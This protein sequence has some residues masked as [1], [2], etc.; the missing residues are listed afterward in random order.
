MSSNYC[1]GKSKSGAPCRAPAGRD[2]LC[3]FH[4]N[5]EQ[6]RALGQL[7]GRR[8][9]HLPADPNGGPLSAIDLRNVLAQAILDVQTKKLPPRRAGAI[10]QLSNT[11]CR[12]I[13]IADLEERVLRL[14]QYIAEHQRSVPNPDEAET[15]G[16]P[17]SPDEDTQEETEQ[18]GS[19]LPDPSQPVDM[20]TENGT[21][22]R[23]RR[24][25][26]GEEP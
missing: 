2:G 22:R 24:T 10:A 6:A 26:D 21:Q 17:T 3:F 8:N 14:E 25:A 23:R 4:A 19:A 5:P 11:Y 9:R 7:G 12:L 18:G 15:N 20:D 16:T 1:R 13:P